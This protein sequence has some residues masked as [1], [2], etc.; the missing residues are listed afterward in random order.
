MNK[1]VFYFEVEHQDNGYDNEQEGGFLVATDY[2]D[3]TAQI[4]AL[5]EPESILFMSL[6]CMDE[7]SLVFP[8][9]KAQHMKE[10]VEGNNVCA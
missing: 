7:L 4:I 3:A 1:Y 10:Y 6:E 2:A 9:E 5:Y 8:L